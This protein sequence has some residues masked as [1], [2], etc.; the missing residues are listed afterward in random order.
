MKISDLASATGLSVEAVRYYEQRGLLNTPKRSQGGHRIYSGVD[1]TRLKFVKRAREWGFS[2]ADV[3]A[4]LALSADEIISCD[5][6]RAI[7]ERRLVEIRSQISELTSA[8]AHLASAVGHCAGGRV[9]NCAVI[10]AIDI[11]NIENAPA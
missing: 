6:V 8:E 9:R 11:G 3:H 4:L 7:A 5:E 2:L 1:L 10:D